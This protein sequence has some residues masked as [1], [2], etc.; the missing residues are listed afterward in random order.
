VEA[1][2]IH[3]RVKAGIREWTELPFRQRSAP[4]IT[5]GAV[6]AIEQI[7]INIESDP[8]PAWRDIDLDSVQHY[9]LNHLPLIMFDFERLDSPYRM[10]RWRKRITSWEVWEGLHF[11]ISDMC[12]IPDGI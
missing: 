8:S 2:E 12:P 3:E 11:K 10:T 1:F 4:E 7:I 5:P 9:V 6:K